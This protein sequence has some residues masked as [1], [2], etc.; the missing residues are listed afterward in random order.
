MNR[1]LTA[2]MFV[3]LAVG[4]SNC[5]KVEPGFAGIKVNMYGDQ[6]GVED[7]P[8]RVGRVWYNPF[9]EEV[10]KFPTHVI[11]VVWT[12]DPMEGSPND[13]SITFNSTEGAT[14]NADVAFAGYFTSNDVPRVFVEFRTDAEA[15]MDGYVR[16]Q[17]RESFNAAASMYKAV[18]ILGAKQTAFLTQ[19]DK[20]VR[21]R[22]EPKGFTI[23]SVSLLTK[24][25]VDD[26]VEKA[27]NGV[28]EANN[29]S[30]EAEQ[31]VRQKK[32]EAE[33]KIAEAEGRAQSILIEAEAQAKANKIVAA[34]ITEEL[35]RYEATKKWSGTVPQV[36]GG[37]VPFISLPLQK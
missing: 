33:Q 16:D 17:V 34:S 26:R 5:T 19:V 27:I 25:R 10:Y 35:I 6:K 37:N 13:E 22:L 29:Q 32:A 18:D 11:R 2:I 1:V 36:T 7:F 30:I 23:D 31:R 3:A 20:E 12:K 8:V 28:I 4:L 15:L 21:S 24:P 9:T 14:M